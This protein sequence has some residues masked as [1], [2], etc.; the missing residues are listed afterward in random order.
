MQFANGEVNFSISSIK[1]IEEPLDDVYD[2]PADIM[3]KKWDTQK[4][5][6]KLK[7]KPKMMICDALLD[8]KI[9][10][11][12]GNIIKNESLFRA[13]LHPESIIGQ[14]PEKKL[15]D[16]IQEVLNFSQDFLKW[17]KINQL[18]RHLE[19]HEKNF[20]PRDNIALHKTDTGKTKRHSYY[21]EKCQE[22]I[23]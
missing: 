15:E 12:S 4:A 7:A 8:Q 6:T 19:A 5:I 14:I 11:G 22:L 3:S 1:L 2:W 10:S 17:R 23:D 20:C 9:F 16:L 13:R 21:C 18:T